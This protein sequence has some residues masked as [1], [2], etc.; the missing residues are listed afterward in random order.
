[1]RNPWTV[2]LGSGPLLA[3][4]IHNGHE[5]LPQLLL[6]SALSDRDRLREE[7]PFTGEMAA[8]IPTHVVVTSSR[9]TVDL[10]RPRESAVYRNPEDAWGL[11]LWSEAPTDEDLNTARGIYDGFY[12]LIAGLIASTVDQHGRFVL[13]DVHSYNHR[14]R[15]PAAAPENPADNPTVNL[16]TGSLPGNWRP[17]ADAF[18]AGISRQEVLGERLDARENVRFRGGHLTKW[19]NENYGTHGCALAIEFKKVFMDEWSGQVDGIV[20]GDLKT[21]L[22]A[23]A[24]LVIEA[25]ETI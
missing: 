4:A 6:R 11:D 20:L 21:A 18:I 3:T 17:V 2:E 23:T 15:G 5:M 7:D 16:G 22:A 8:A 9:F 19:V 13:Y 1:M 14:R 12:G 24:T 10:N 25:L